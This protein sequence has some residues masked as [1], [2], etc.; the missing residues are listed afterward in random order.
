MT[1]HWGGSNASKCG[2][3]VCARVHGACRDLSRGPM[4]PQKVLAAN[5]RGGL[6]IKRYRHGPQAALRFID[7][8]FMLFGCYQPA[9]DRSS[10]VDVFSL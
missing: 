9:P 8:R 3:G 7:P 5:N 10:A 6:A 1:A 2:P 4:M